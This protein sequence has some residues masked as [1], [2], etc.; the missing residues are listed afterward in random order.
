MSVEAIDIDAHGTDAMMLRALLGAS[1]PQL[2][3][4]AATP[5]R[6]V[7]MTVGY[8]ADCF[9]MAGGLVGS[10]TL[11]C[12]TG[13]ACALPEQ[14]GELVLALSEAASVPL[15]PEFGEQPVP[16]PDALVIA[17]D[18]RAGAADDLAAALHIA[19]LDRVPPWLKDL[20]HGVS[21]AFVVLVTNENGTRVGTHLLGLPSGWGHLEEHDGQLAITPLPFTDV[22]TELEDIGL[23]TAS[24]AADR[25]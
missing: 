6:V 9:V 16:V 4:I 23:L 11:T 25:T 1:E 20:A 8:D 17:E 7:A 14:L 21:A 3:A 15:S 19:E 13:P 12:I 22:L 2:C 10:S 5:T 24:L 18:V